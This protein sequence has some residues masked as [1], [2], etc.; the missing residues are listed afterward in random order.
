MNRLDE[1]INQYEKTD[2]DELEVFELL[3][4][5]IKERSEIEKINAMTQI[6][7]ARL[8]RFA[9]T[10]HMYFDSTK[11]YNAVFKKRFAELGGMTPT[12]SKI[13]GWG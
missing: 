11:P 1:L 5:L 6:Q 3:N 2:L 13:I 8:H 4:L 12:I 10:G 9:P 7:M